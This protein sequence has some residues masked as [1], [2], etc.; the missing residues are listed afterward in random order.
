MSRAAATQ[1]SPA[2]VLAGCQLVE[3]GRKL[4]VLDADGQRLERAG[5]GSWEWLFAVCEQLLI[6]RWS[7]ALGLSWTLHPDHLWMRL[8]WAEEDQEAAT[9]RPFGAALRWLIEEA[10]AILAARQAQEVQAALEAQQAQE[11]QVVLEAQAAQEPEPVRVV[12]RLCS[13]GR[14]R[15]RVRRWPALWRWFVAAAQSVGT[16]CWSHDAARGPP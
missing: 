11:A 4:A 6:E 12:V 3:Q 8:W 1:L 9:W 2:L 7:E 14:R 15:R 13:G 10:P 5:R 16:A